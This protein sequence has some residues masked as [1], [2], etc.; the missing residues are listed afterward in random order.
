ME[1]TV[2][3]PLLTTEIDNQHVYTVSR[4][5]VFNERCSNWCL[6]RCHDTRAINEKDSV[7]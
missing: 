5:T 4:T 3:P 2:I 7:Y 6:P 1:T